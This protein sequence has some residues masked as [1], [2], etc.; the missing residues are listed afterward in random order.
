[1]VGPPG[2]EPGFAGLFGAPLQRVIIHSSADP[3]YP[4]EPAFSPAFTGVL[5]KL[6][7]GPTYVQFALRLKKPLVNQWNMTVPT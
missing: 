4:L 7:Y 2:F 6:H 1:M 5:A 3:Q